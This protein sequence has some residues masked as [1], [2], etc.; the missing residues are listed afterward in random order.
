MAEEYNI[1]AAEKQSNKEAE[2]NKEADNKKEEYNRLQLEDESGEINEAKLDG[3]E[4]F[5]VRFISVLSA[6]IY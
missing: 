2:E 6:I 1:V 4:M 3:H 5:R